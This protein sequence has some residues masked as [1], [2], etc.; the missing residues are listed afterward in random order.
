[1]KR[2]QAK[3]VPWYEDYFNDGYEK[4]AYAI[5]NQWA[6]D[7]RAELKKF[8]GGSEPA[9]WRL[10]YLRYEFEYIARLVELTG[11]DI[12][13]NELVDKLEVFETEAWEMKHGQR[14]T[15]RPDR[16]NQKS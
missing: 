12:E 15:K 9:S 1:M 8:L 4:L 13:P 3:I 6:N 14:R 16:A 2:E 5:V 7:Y 11:L 10:D